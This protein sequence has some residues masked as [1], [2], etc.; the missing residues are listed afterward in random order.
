MVLLR[1]SF[2]LAVSARTIVHKLSSRKRPWASPIKIPHFLQSL[3]WFA[4]RVHGNTEERVT[5]RLSDRRIEAFSPRYSSKRQWNTRAR[6]IDLPL[7]PGYVFCRTDAIAPI[8][9]LAADG[10]LG[11]VQRDGQPAVVDERELQAI[12]AMVNSGYPVQPWP[13]V[14]HGQRVRVAGGPLKNVEGILIQ[15]TTFIVSLSL[16][17]RS[18]AAEVDTDTSVVAIRAAGA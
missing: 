5:A 6:D 11:V 13:F 4:L 7:F 2:L 10:I 3:R 16:L 8:A 9:D 14:A 12:R 18:V 17:Q 15:E 1:A